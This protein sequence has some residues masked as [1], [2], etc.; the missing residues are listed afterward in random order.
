MTTV[1]VFASTLAMILVLAVILALAIIGAYHLVRG[2]AEAVVRDHGEEAEQVGLCP[3]CN[4]P[5]PDEDP[6]PPTTKDS[7]TDHA[8][9]E[10]HDETQGEQG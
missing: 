8:G 10:D 2:V 5:W 3:M 4:R 9:T 6:V 1:V 7:S